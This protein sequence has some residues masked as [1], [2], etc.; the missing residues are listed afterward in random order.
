MGATIRLVDVAKRFYM[1]KQPSRSLKET[2]IRLVK[3]QLDYDAFLAL[4]GVTLSIEQGQAV[5]VIGTNGSGKSTLFKIMSGI[6]RP[7]RGTVEV[8]GRISP[9]IELS[10]GFHPELTG[11]ENIY[12]NGAIYG[13]RTA[14]IAAK[15][16]GICAFADIGDFVHSPVR[17]YSSG[18]MA[19]LA[20]AL[21]IN[22]DADI[23]LMDEVLAVG[24]IGFQQRCIAKIKDLKRAGVTI[25][26]VS[27]DMRS[28]AE[29]A[30][31]VVLLD[32]GV[33]KAD[34]EPEAVIA[35]YLER[36]RT[37]ARPS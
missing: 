14:E 21:A 7:T 2:L 18:M 22:V 1:A 31:R 17:V 32:H 34:G 13:M 11:I 19:R 28:V 6:L 15:I 26:Y 4:D 29:V 36:I 24:D 3:R 20:F 37:A 8:T 25:V 30:D 27:Q 23:L 10:A 12:L 9:L 5:G 16:A 33:V 35:E